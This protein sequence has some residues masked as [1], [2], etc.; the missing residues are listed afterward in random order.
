M[1]K[2]KIK[3]IAKV[4]SGQGAPQDPAVFSDKG[5]PFIRAGSLEKLLLGESENSLEK[6]ES[7]TAIKYKL[8]LYPHGTV[9]FAKSG[10]SATKNRIY[11]LKNPCYVV[12]HLATLGAYGAH[13]DNFLSM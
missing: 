3:D 12:S 8:K 6:I 4:G 1:N 11:K 13:I 2:K 10:M 5:A 7:N 9:I